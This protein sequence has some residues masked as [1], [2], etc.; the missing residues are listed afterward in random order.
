MADFLKVF[1]GMFILRGVAAAYVPALHAQTQMNPRV[2]GLHAVFTN[3][4]FGGG[5]LDVRKMFALA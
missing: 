3:V 5:N 2:S 4:D 1:R